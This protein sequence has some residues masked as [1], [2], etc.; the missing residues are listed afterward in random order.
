M[1]TKVE[2]VG[3]ST[4][5]LERERRES[6]CVLGGEDHSGGT[7]KRESIYLSTMK[8]DRAF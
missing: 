1:V 8:P 7:G 4:G 2:K 6:V 3:R 5:H